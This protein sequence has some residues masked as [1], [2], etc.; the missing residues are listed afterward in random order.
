MNGFL[1]AYRG[2]AMS[3]FR[4]VIGLLFLEHGLS[5]LIGFPVGMPMAHLPPLFLAAGVIETVGGALIAVGLFTRWAALICSGEMAVAYFMAH[6][7]HGFYPLVNKG[8]AAILFC[9]G[10]LL[11]A[12][13]GPGPWAIDGEARATA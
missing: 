4:V 5:K 3:V 12:A 1:N 13:I 8:E 9:F 7:P 6:F 10:F 11:I 2:P